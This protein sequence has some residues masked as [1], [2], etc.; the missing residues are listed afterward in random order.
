MYYLLIYPIKRS[1]PIYLM[2]LPTSISTTKFLVRRVADV[3][4]T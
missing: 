4:L 3:A 1:V 2:P